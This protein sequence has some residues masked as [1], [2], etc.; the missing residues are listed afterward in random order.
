MTEKARA[1]RAF[2]FGATEC[3][4]RFPGSNHDRTAGSFG[5]DL[6]RPA[7][8]NPFLYTS[9][10]HEAGS[11]WARTHCLQLWLAKDQF[12]CAWAGVRAQGAFAG[13]RGAGP[14][15]YCQHSAGAGDR[16]SAVTS[17]AHY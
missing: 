2:S 6:Y 1:T 7:S 8:H 13:A 9:V 10:G 4:A 3:V 12:A 15:L 17:L 16:A 11:L 14:V 5:A